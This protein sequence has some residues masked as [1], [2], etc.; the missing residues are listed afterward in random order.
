MT[1]NTGLLQSFGSYS[2]A[3]ALKGYQ[4][5]AGGLS[6]APAPSRAESKAAGAGMWVVVT[7]QSARLLWSGTGRLHSRGRQRAGPRAASGR[8][9][10]G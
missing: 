10:D 9:G 7:Q 5:T 2:K 1:S 8:A 6:A 3:E 4:E